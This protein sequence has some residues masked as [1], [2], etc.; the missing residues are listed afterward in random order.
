MR[1]GIH[2]W[3]EGGSLSGSPAD[4]TED[5]TEAVTAPAVSDPHAPAPART[6][7]AAARVAPDAAPCGPCPH[8]DM[9]FEGWAAGSGDG[10]ASE[11]EYAS[12]DFDSGAETECGSA[13]EG[14]HVTV[15]CD[16]D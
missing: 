4:V 5:G 15:M 16:S 8:L 9:P 2:T 14:Q 13:L 12:A 1:Q 10:W 6:A 3:L 11:A 7:S